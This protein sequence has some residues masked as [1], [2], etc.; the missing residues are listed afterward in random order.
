M[1][2]K[3]VTLLNMSSVTTF[4]IG[5]ANGRVYKTRTLICLLVLRRQK[6]DLIDVCELF[7]CG[8]SKVETRDE[9]WIEWK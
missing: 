9:T 6:N 5:E 3:V 4:L 2:R 1:I 7:H 8:Q